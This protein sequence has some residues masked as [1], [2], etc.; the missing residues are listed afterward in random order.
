MKKAKIR[1][2]ST[3]LD[4][5]N[6]ICEEIVQ[7]IKKE[8][9][10]YSGP[11]PLPTKRLRVPV[12]KGPSGQGSETFET[13]EMRIHKRLIEVAASDRIMRRLIRLAIPD[14]V[15]IEIKMTK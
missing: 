13:W 10:D 15:N 3:D 5:L 2:S 6:Q 11:I 12:R 7:M 4:K 9:V 1:I 8:G 14:E